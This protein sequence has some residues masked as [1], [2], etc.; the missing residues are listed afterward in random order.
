MT[1]LLVSYRAVEHDC[2]L[3]TIETMIQELCISFAMRRVLP[4]DS[5]SS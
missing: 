5:H 1:A 2:P 4:D 3:P